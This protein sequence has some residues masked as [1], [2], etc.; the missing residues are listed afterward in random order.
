[1]PPPP[2]LLLHLPLNVTAGDALKPSALRLERAAVQLPIAGK[3]NDI[4]RHALQ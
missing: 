1:M 2:R 4:V 3:S